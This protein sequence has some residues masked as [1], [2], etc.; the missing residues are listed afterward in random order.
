MKNHI[1][2]FCGKSSSGKDTCASIMHK[3]FNHNFVVSTTTRPKRSREVEGVHYYFKTLEEFNQLEAEGKLLEKRHYD[4]IQGSDT[5]RWFYGIERKEFESE[6]NHVVVVDLNGL[7]ML[8][9]EFGDRVVSI[10]LD[11][12]EKHRMLRAV[13]RD[14]NFNA[15]EWTRRCEDDDVIFEDVFSKVD[16]VVEN[17]NLVSCLADIT[18]YL[19]EN[20]YL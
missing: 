20:D 17:V 14:V 13:G 3:A 10:Y 2:V 5:V 12:P 15:M 6:G 7:E 11:A 16:C 8:K 18:K 19:T 9:Q 4:A 1:L